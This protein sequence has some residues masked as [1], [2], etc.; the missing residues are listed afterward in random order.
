MIDEVSFSGTT[1]AP[2]PQRFE[3]GTPN[4]S[5]AIGLATAI[6]YLRQHDMNELACHENELLQ[7]TQT[8]LLS[9]PGLTIHGTT[10]NKASVISF[11][12]EGVHP[13]D[14][15]TLLDGEGIAIRTGHHCCQPL[16][17]KLGVEATA[18]ASYSMYNTLEDVNIFTDAVKRAVQILG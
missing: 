18:R 2:T 8:E 17:K 11:L 7:F 15:A 3:A 4:V 14:L 1:Y 6:D 16:M 5:G 13:H 9:I 10:P 12:I